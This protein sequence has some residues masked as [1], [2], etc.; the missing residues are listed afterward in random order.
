MTNNHSGQGAS[1]TV[2]SLRAPAA[3]ARSI[4]RFD[5]ASL[6]AI[7]RAKGNDFQQ[8]T[9]TAL[10]Q[11]EATRHQQ[12][13]AA[14]GIVLRCADYAEA[15]DT[16]EVLVAEV[17]RLTEA[18]AFAHGEGCEWPDDPLP[19][20]CIARRLVDKFELA[21]PETPERKVHDQQ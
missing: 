2:S 11:G 7:L 6:L 17:L 18:L 13:A 5:P 8:R 21:P 9:Y 4:Y 10:Q 3:I 19:L 1:C 12:Q 16:I 14:S 20:D 15:A